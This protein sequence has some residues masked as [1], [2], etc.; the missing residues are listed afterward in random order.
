MLS[1]L[2]VSVLSDRFYSFSFPSNDWSM[3]IT[4]GMSNSRIWFR[5]S[6]LKSPSKTEPPNLSLGFGD[7]ALMPLILLPTWHSIALKPGPSS[8]L[9]S[10]YKSLAN[11]F[12]PLTILS[13]SVSPY[14]SVHVGVFIS[15]L[16]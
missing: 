5:S 15:D 7:G 16:F 11:D 3:T 1:L 4:A 9:V 2:I 13:L 6:Y 8:L 10:D 12:S 14:D